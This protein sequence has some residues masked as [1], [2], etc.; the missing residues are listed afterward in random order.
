MSDME[1]FFELREKLRLAVSS[2]VFASGDVLND[3]GS[4]VAEFL[5][6]DSLDLIELVVA[7]E[8]NGT[9]IRTIGDWL[10]AMD[11]VRVKQ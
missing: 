9:K 4:E 7:L 3:R 8:E 11:Q 1:P 6:V 5:G 10:R 2:G